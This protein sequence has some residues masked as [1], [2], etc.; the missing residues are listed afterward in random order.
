MDVQETTFV[1]GDERGRQHAQEAGQ[2]DAVRR[3]RVDH[4][5]KRA[6]EPGTVV[7]CPGVD[8]R[9]G[10]AGLGRER[11][12]GGIGPARDDARDA[13]IPTFAR[14]RVGDRAHVGA[15]PRDHDHEALHWLCFG[16]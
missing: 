11:Q 1:A 2:R 5:S 8:D 15:A 7:E 3:V 13:R 9:G 10:E 12:A 16:L 6:F 14:A 4:L